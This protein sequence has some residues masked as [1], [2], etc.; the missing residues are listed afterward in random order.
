M[1]PAY[2]GTAVTPEAGAPV[3]SKQQAFQIAENAVQP[4]AVRSIL[5]QHHDL[6]PQL[7]PVIKIGDVPVGH[8]DAA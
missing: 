3:I 8:A 2:A 7:H 4:N 6:R 1:V 5:L